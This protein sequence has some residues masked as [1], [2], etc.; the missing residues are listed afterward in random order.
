VTFDNKPLTVSGSRNI[1]FFA[2]YEF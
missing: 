2:R 1:R